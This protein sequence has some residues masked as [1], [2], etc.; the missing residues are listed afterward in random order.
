MNLDLTRG[1]ILY[2]HWDLPFTDAFAETVYLDLNGAE[3]AFQ[4]GGM[5][6]ASFA[7]GPEESE[8]VLVHTQS[9][10]GLKFVTQS[11]SWLLDGESTYELT[12]INNGGDSAILTDEGTVTIHG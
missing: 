8:F 12:V 3:L 7:L 9:G 5:T 6:V 11:Y 4:R 10:W 2:M 1:Q